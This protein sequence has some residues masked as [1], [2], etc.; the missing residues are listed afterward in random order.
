MVGKWCGGAE[1]CTGRCPSWSDAPGRAGEN[2]WPA[3][4]S[5]AGAGT[6]T[7]LASIAELLTYFLIVV[8][9]GLM[10]QVE[11]VK[12]TGRLGVAVLALVR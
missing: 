5:S 6:V 11:L 1:V 9:A 8:Q 7:W 3:G 12:I 4:G 10:L 2:H